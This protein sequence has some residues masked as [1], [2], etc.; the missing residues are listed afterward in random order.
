[1][2][3]KADSYKRDEIK[4]RKQLAQAELTTTATSLY[5]PNTNVETVITSIVITATSSQNRWISI[6]H[7][8]DGTTYDDTTVL[9]DEQDISSSETFIYDNEIYMNGAGNLAF[10]A[11][12]SNIFTATIYGIERQKK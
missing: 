8:D 6:F 2:S 9:I 5:T 7:D 10:E 4:E 12:Q 11:E 3:R 1:M